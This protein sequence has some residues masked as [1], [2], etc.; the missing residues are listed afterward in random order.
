M[1]EQIKRDTLV[2][3]DM[4]AVLS[5]THLA[6]DL[7]GFLLAMCEAISN[8]MDAIQSRFGDKAKEN[9][10]IRIQLRDTNDPNKIIISVTDNGIGLT[11]RNYTSFKTPYSGFKLRQKGCGFGRFIAFKIFARIPLPIGKNRENYRRFVKR[12]SNRHQM[13]SASTC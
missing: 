7:Q 13:K 5:R 8:A 1:P 10:D 6:Y 12:R 2:K 9:G 11:D 3:P 4:Q